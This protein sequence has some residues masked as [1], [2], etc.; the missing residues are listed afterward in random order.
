MNFDDL[1]AADR[2]LVADAVRL[3]MRHP[4]LLPADC[5]RV[6]RPDLSDDDCAR[7]A[8]AFTQRIAFFRDANRYP[9]FADPPFPNKGLAS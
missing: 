6:N 9:P 7:L 8:P 3:G 5:F 1:P 2:L 4:E